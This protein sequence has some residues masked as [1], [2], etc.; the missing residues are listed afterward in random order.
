LR[1]RS[2]ISELGFNTLNIYSLF[3]FAFSLWSSHK[4]IPPL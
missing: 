2:P 4:N 1:E 3:F